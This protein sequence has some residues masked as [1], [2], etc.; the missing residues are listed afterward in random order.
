MGVPYTKL[1][2]STPPAA[3]AAVVGDPQLDGLDYDDV[4]ALPPAVM[5]PM[6]PV[7]IVVAD[8]DSTFCGCSAGC[9]DA[10]LERSEHN[11][12]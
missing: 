8:Y 1:L 7:N 10:Q 9:D 4:F 2:T 3:S 12:L 6:L 5:M 11:D